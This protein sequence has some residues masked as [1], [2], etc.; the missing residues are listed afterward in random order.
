[1]SVQAAGRHV[2]RYAYGLLRQAEGR[3]PRQ[4]EVERG[5][6]LMLNDSLIALY[7][8]VRRE[9]GTPNPADVYQEPDEWVQP[10]ALKSH[11]LPRRTEESARLEAPGPAVQEERELTE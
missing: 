9:I 3:P 4:D 1:M 2:L 11:G 10:S 6:M 7:A 5:P 8:E